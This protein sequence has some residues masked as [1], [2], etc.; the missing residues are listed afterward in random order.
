MLLLLCD[1]TKGTPQLGIIRTCLQ[2]QGTKQE[3]HM[4]VHTG[5]TFSVL[6]PI[7]EMVT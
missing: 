2:G 7:V 1:V 3:K 6:Y 4:C 5:W